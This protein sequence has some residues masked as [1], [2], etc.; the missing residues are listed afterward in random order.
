MRGSHGLVAS[1]HISV[2]FC[3][4]MRNRFLF[5]CW[6][7]LSHYFDVPSLKGSFYSSIHHS[8]P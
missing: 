4:T 7:L 6:L 3:T 8:T 5:L 1:R 2:G